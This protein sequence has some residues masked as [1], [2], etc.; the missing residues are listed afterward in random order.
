M[1]G[2]SWI[3]WTRSFFEKPLLAVLPCRSTETLKTRWRA[4]A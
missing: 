1:E 2:R 3:G 4:E